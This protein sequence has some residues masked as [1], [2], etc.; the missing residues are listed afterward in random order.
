[1][2]ARDRSFDDLISDP[3]IPAG[4][5]GPVVVGVKRSAG[6]PPTMSDPRPRLIALLMRLAPDLAAELWGVRD[7]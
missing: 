4:V 5:G 2:A 1:V 7:P 3:L 6:E